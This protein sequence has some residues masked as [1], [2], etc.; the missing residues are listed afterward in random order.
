MTRALLLLAVGLGI[1][2]RAG[3]AAAPAAIAPL[4]SDPVEAGKKLSAELRALA[5]TEDSITRGKLKIRDRDGHTTEVPVVCKVLAGEPSWRAVYETLGTN[6]SVAERFT[7]THT[8]GAANQYLV[9][10]ALG[11]NDRPASATGLR[12]DQA[13][14]ALGASDFWL[15]DLGLDFLHWP[16]Q[17]VLKT[18][19]RKGRSCRV[20]ES[21]PGPAPAVPYGRVLSWVDIETG[22]LI[23][24]EAYDTEN[25]LIK[26]FS[27]R[28]F[29]KV[30]G[31][32]QL[33]EMEIR[34]LKKRSRSWLQFDF[35]REAGPETRPS[36]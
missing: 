15:I 10:R 4:P 28:S 33:E 12:L 24:A 8:L 3:R 5:P 27:V 6:G 7:V 25:K 19:M 11:T 29:E 30:N 23:L 34:D 36:P 16:E 9:E 2:L 13:T 31:R 21:R 14:L 32:W 22:G 26:E 18:Q 35:T 20:L 1:G 17:R